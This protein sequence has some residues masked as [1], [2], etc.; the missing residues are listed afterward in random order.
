MPNSIKELLSQLLPLHHAEQERLKKEKEEGKC[1]NVFSALNMCSDEVR[2]HSRLLATLLNPKA[3]HG[4]ENEFLKSFLTALGLPE[5]YI[6]HCKE[7]IV[8]RLIGEVTE[9]NGGRIDIIL[10]DRG[11]A[12]IIEN[13]IYA[14]DQ[15]NQLL[16]YHNYG[17]KTFGENN[18]KLVYLTL[19]GS[20]P[21]PYSLGGEHFEFI[22]LSYEQNIL[23]LLEKLVKTLPQKPVHSTV[24]DYITIIK[25]LTHQDMDTKY[26][27]SIIEE[28]IKYDNIDVT[29]ELLLLQKQIGDKL[30]SDYIIKPLKGLGFNERQDDNGA[31]WKSL[32]S[33]RN[34]FIVIK[35]DEAYWKE[36]WI[37]VASEDKTIPLQPKL[38]CFTDEPTQNY[39]Y[40]W[41][42]ISDNEGN[43]WHDI[44]QYP[45]IGKEEVLKWIKNKISEIESC[46][47]I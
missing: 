8:E 44:A 16:R 46:F 5:D 35:T 14:G 27:Q 22:K 24:E 19:Y 37:A 29:S 1:F 20:D 39:P 4:L 15:P 26:Q 32:N 17:V 43:N 31:L 2:L 21:S 28:A 23:K 18:F 25:Q 9:T 47:K 12:V 11:H 36:A 30:R 45:A 34:L 42:W 41:S 7:Q 33:K 38:D 13:K 3:N 10:E 40:G 6:T